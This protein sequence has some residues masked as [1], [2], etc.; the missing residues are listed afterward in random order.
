[1]LA[2]GQGV[3]RLSSAPNVE[4][5]VTDSIRIPEEKR[6]DRLHV[7]SVGELLS[8]AIRYI[9]SEQSVSSLFETAGSRG[10]E[11]MATAQLS[12]TPRDGTGKG[13]ARTLRASGKIPGVIY[14]H[15]RDPQAL[16]IDTRELEKLL[17][18]ISAESTVIDL[19]LDGKSART[20][21]REIQRHPY[22][23]QILHIDFQELVAVRKSPCAFQS[24]SL[25][26]PTEFVRT[27][28]FS[29]R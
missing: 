5:T 19:S 24:F 1:M 13:S 28:V 2:F 16:A 6:F 11:E 17:S 23:R 7:L 12:A 21:I 8:K 18:K 22:K 14:G 3:E 29:T 15:G 20:L 26:F 27:A 10:L 25:E 9:H 4:V